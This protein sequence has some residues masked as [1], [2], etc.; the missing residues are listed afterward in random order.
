MKTEAKKL[1]NGSELIFGINYGQ[2]SRFDREIFT[3]MIEL[4]VESGATHIKVDALPFKHNSWVLPDNTDPYA[5]WCNHSASFFRLFPPEELQEWIPAEQ[6][7]AAREVME[8]KISMIRQYDLKVTAYAVEPVWLP[9]GVYRAHP[10]WRGPQCELG[11]IAC[12]PYFAPSIDEPEVLDLYRRAVKEYCTAFPEVDQFHF[13][14]ND[15]GAGISW[16]P[17]IYPG[18]NGPT[19][20]RTKDRGTRIAGW[21]NAVQEGANEAGQSLRLDAHYAG[22]MTDTA[23]SARKHV[24]ENIYISSRDKNG[25]SFLNEQANLPGGIWSATYPV[26][27]MSDPLGFIGGLQ[28]IYD[29]KENGEKRKVIEIGEQDIE[30]AEIMLNKVINNPGS[31]LLSRTETS[32]AVA[33]E[34]AGNEKNAEE[35]ISVW[36]L[37]SKA[38]H[39]VQQIRQKGFGSVLAFCGVS[40]RWITRPLVPEPEKLTDEEKTHYRDYLYSPGDTKDDPNFGFVLGKAVF[41]GESVMWMSRWCLFEAINLLNNAAAKAGEIASEA[42]DDDA[43]KRMQLFAD[44]ISA[45][46]CLVANAK[47]TIMYQYALDIKNQPQY[48]PNQ[49]DYDDN[50]IYDQRALNFRKVAREEL[51]NITTLVELIEAHPEDIILDFARGEDEEESVFMLGPD[52]INDLKRK[53]D[54]MLDHWQDY[55][56][57]FPATKV[58]DFEPEIKGNISNLPN[59]SE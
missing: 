48:G 39:C 30:Q 10:R 35:L 54:I 25:R 4:A 8:E 29:G 14:L 17:N 37:V 1:L 23:I 57:L 33:G 7:A 9:E 49:M 44:R 58:Y 40:M 53:Q 59:D 28:S 50:I 11:R 34:F 32:L 56:N 47:N 45:Y 2:S 16:S 12:R 41:R 13:L 20:F 26:P 18:M 5:A 52:I 24:K 51:D 55:E 19:K 3:K 27:G 42:K 15:S 46:S 43:K 36:N 6:A 31:G 38:T 21:L 22:M